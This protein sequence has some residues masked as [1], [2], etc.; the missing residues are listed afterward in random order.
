MAKIFKV[1]KKHHKKSFA[2]AAPA[3]PR[4]VPS[5][6][7][8][9]VFTKNN[10]TKNPYTLIGLRRW[11][12][13]TGFLI[14]KCL[15]FFNWKIKNPVAGVHRP[16]GRFCTPVGYS[17]SL[18][19]RLVLRATQLIFNR[20]MAMII[21]EAEGQQQQPLPSSASIIIVLTQTEKHFKSGRL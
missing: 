3:S 6:F 7:C 19:L 13:P 4:R 2:P 15:F 12:Q 14:F 20:Q 18:W 17:S 11:S 8:V 9:M 21:M 1:Q 5:L 16:W 10:A